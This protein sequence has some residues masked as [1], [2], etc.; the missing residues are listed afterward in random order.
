[1]SLPHRIPASARVTVRAR[2][3]DTRRHM[4]TPLNE[5]IAPMSRARRSENRDGAWAMLIVFVTVVL[6]AGVL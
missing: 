2:D 4:P 1:M 6:I 3:W 5:R